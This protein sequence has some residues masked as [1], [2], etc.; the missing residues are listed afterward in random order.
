MRSEEQSSIVGGLP[1]FLGGVA[2]VIVFGTGLLLC[3]ARWLWLGEMAFA[4]RFPVGLLGLASAIALYWGGGRISVFF[5]VACASFHLAPELTMYMAPTGTPTP[6]PESPRIRV[7]SCVVDP[8][9]PEPELLRAWL[10]VEAPDVVALQGLSPAWLSALE[11]VEAD[12]PWRAVEPESASGFGEDTLGV[13]LLSRYE[14]DTWRAQSTVGKAP[15]LD[16]RLSLVAAGSAGLV[17][18]A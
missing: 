17:S 18:P 16:A 14:I 8:D 3:S 4:L 9:L 15:V 7:A 13:C 1:G 5:A 12:Y 10:M 6:A 2:L 11:A